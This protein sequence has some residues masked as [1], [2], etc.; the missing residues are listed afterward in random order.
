ML[1]FFIFCCCVIDKSEL[2]L[3]EQN[4]TDSSV[5]TDQ[6]QDM[7]LFSSETMLQ[8]IIYKEK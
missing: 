1:G 8:R 5:K 2:D 3:T 6:I 7:I 4:Q